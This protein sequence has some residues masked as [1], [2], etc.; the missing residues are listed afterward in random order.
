MSTSGT[1]RARAKTVEQL[2][3][4]EEALAIQRVSEALQHVGEE[5]C[6]ATDLR[7]RIRR[8]PYLAA[9]LGACLG[10]VGG[11]WVLRTLGHVLGAASAIPIPRAVLAS[12]R[13]IRGLR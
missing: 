13:G 8:S 6:G 7:G 11:P 10:F 12:L 9:G 3:D 5:L 1:R 4:R 2:L